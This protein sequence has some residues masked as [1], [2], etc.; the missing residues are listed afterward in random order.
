[1]SMPRVEGDRPPDQHRMRRLQRTKSSSSRGVKVVFGSGPIPKVRKNADFM[2]PQK[3]FQSKCSRPDFFSIQEERR[4]QL[5]KKLTVM[6]SLVMKVRMQ[7]ARAPWTPKFTGCV[8]GG[9]DRER[10]IASQHIRVS[11]GGRTRFSNERLEEESREKTQPSH[12][13][14]WREIKD[15]KS[16]HTAP[17]TYGESHSD[18]NVRRS[19]PRMQSSVK[20]DYRSAEMVRQTSRIFR[21]NAQGV[22]LNSRRA[23]R[24]PG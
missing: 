19:P 2:M 9:K 20:H 6:K 22:E 12:L 24:A 3:F 1:M 14:N 11:R 18:D 13:M 4:S 21:C 15:E 23:P 8:M 10:P 16:F 5:V 17:R 7:M